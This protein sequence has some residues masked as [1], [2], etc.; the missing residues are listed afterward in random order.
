[1]NGA[2]VGSVVEADSVLGFVRQRLDTKICTRLPWGCTVLTEDVENVD[3]HPT[4]YLIEQ[5][6]QVEIR[7]KPTAGQGL[8]NGGS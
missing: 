2:I 6:G 3:S 1:M 5:R 4:V 8:T 7:R